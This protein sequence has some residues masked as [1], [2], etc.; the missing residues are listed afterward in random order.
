MTL[1]HRQTAIVRVLL[2][3]CRE[4]HEPISYRAVAERIGVSP[5]TAYR[6]LR[7]AEAKGYARAVYAQRPSVGGVGRSAVLFAPTDLARRLIA[8]VAGPHAD[9]DWEATKS[10]VLE[11]L[12]VRRVP[13]AES[14][15]QLLSELDRPASALATAG[16]LIAALMIALEELRPR[17]G[18]RDLPIRLADT[19]SRVGL[20]ALGGLLVGLAWADQRRRSL[21]S[22]LERELQRLTAALGTLSPAEEA[23]LADFVEQMSGLL[24]ARRAAPPLPDETAASGSGPHAGS[25]PDEPPLARRLQPRLTP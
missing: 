19:G 13:D 20:A 22:R 9:A 11:A 14:V 23:D 24:R 1:T 5:P 12:S 18:N 17:P 2:D 25:G 3:L 16:R 4:P 7:L 6:L 15:Q 21:T 10:R 8:D